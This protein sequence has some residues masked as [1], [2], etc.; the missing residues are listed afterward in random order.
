M[1]APAY[2]AAMSNTTEKKTQKTALITGASGGIGYEL[3]KLFAGDG[4]SLVLVARNK[5]LMDENAPE[6]RKLGAPW[7]M[8]YP[9]DLVDLE[10]PEDVFAYTERANLQ[11]DILVNN[12][13]YGVRGA[14]AK[15]NLDDELEMMQLNM[16]A[17]THLTKLYLPQM[18]AR[19]NGKI[20]QVA[21][22]AAFQPGPFMA[23]YFASKAYVL[24]FSEALYEELRGTGVTVTA[25]CPG[26]TATGFFERADMTSTKL[27]KSGAMDSKTVAEQG[28]RAMMDGKPLVITGLRNK[29]LTFSERFAPR[30]WV[31]KIVR[32]MQE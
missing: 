32:G 3:A 1:V 27:F 10:A 5:K 20:L 13:G 29:L 22:T 2:F 7:V 21:S 31:R 26:P 14:F 18:V 17:L 16:V 11:I 8:N 25:L 19:G 9:K 30:S 12:A 24:S 6:L 4:Y 15:T 23:V 28:Y